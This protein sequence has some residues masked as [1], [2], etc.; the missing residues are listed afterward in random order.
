[1]RIQNR[2]MEEQISLWSRCALGEKILGGNK[3]ATIEEFRRTVPL[4][5]Y[6]DYADILLLKQ[7]DML[8]DTPI[9]W[10]RTTWEGGRHPIKVAPYTQAMLETYR[11]NILACLLLSTSHETG[12]V[13][14]ESDG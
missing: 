6:E 11:N 8:P 2:L 7:G 14:R 3:P 5:T 1:M 12:P 13:Q 10:I 4:T 9:I